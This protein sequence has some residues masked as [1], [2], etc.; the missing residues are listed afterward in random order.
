MC[1]GVSRQKYVT[2][3]KGKG[4]EKG[5][6]KGF[7]TEG[8]EVGEQRSQRRETR[9]L[10]TTGCERCQKRWL[11]K[12]IRDGQKAPATQIHPGSTKRT[13]EGGRYK[14]RSAAGTK[15][16][17][18]RKAGPTWNPRTRSSV[19]PVQGGEISI[20]LIG[21]RNEGPRAIARRRRSADRLSLRRAMA[22]GN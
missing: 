16:R 11:R 15:A 8:A 9:T 5:G 22:R 12:G 18:R 20:V 4:G 7:N 2:E 14:G 3:G 17:G 19:S 6:G 21:Y 10:K 1:I 13:S